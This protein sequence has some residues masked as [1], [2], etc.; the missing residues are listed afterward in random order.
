M[1][2]EFSQVVWK[3]LSEIVVVPSFW[4]GHLVDKKF[5]PEHDSARGFFLLKRT[6][7]L[8]S[9]DKCLLIGGH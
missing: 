9:L 7:F 5:E 2:V 6:F 4:L 1:I 8:P 3:A